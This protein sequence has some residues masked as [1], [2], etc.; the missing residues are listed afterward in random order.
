MP[1]RP[2][3]RALLVA[4]AATLAASA[5]ADEAAVRRATESLVQAWNRHDV[6]AWAE[7]LTDDVWY[8]EGVDHYGRYKGR[9]QVVGLI[10]DKVRS[11]DLEWA[12][13]RVL[14]ARPDGQVGVVLVERLQVL[15]R[16]DG[17]YHSVFT[18][19]PS[20]A[21]WRR[22]PDGRWRLSHFTSNRG[23]ALSE[24]RNDEQAVAGAA[25]PAASAPA[26][27]ISGGAGAQQAARPRPPRGAPA[28]EPGE[29]TAFYGRYA[30]GCNY[31]HGRPPTL[32]G[33]IDAASRI[34][35]VGAAT[36]DGASLRAAMARESLGNPMRVVLDDPALTD[37]ALEAVRR[38]LVAVRDGA[39]PEAVVF[40]GPGSHREIEVRNE[41]AGR[42][43]PARLALLRVSGPFTIDTARSTCRRG[44]MI[45]GQSS[46]RLVLRAAAGPTAASV[47]GA[48]EV[49]FA[50]GSG[51]DPQ[52]RRSTLRVGS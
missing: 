11:T 24:I 8:P 44:V 33:S 32:P 20:Y 45:A 2:G 29:Y 28:V 30:N 40:E 16:V 39:V 46:C 10:G 13:T 5:S 34:V 1:M 47:A 26:P 6:Q 51:L 36:A 15:P 49:R 23:R 14:Q 48:L 35:A 9:E 3:L 25:V 43:A 7:H 17:R 50:P 18:S 52:P 19:D 38:Y 21:R 4:A 22:E 42:D 37:D 12:I 27:S 41:R 31:C